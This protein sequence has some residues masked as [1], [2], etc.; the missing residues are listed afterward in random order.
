LL[1]K[2]RGEVL[3]KPRQFFGRG[4]H[5]VRCHEGPLL[6]EGWLGGGP[7]GPSGPWVQATRP[8]G[9]SKIFPAAVE[10]LTG[11]YPLGFHPP[12]WWPVVGSGVRLAA[13][14]GDATTTRAHERQDRTGR[15]VLARPE[16]QAVVRQAVLEWSRG[17]LWVQMWAGLVHD[18]DRGHGPLTLHACSR[19]F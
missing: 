6:T 5:V 9:E 15:R 11:L 2:E 14:E 3:V 17:P 1:A 13:I 10:L 4:T 7:A 18:D 19:H 8:C 16:A 12:P